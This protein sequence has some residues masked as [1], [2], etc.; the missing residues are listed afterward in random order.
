MDTIY[1][2][3]EGKPNGHFAN[4]ERLLNDKHKAGALF[5]FT[6]GLVFD[7]LAGESA[8]NIV[9]QRQLQGASKLLI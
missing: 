9:Q 4:V 2:A 7:G 5:D 6:A 1:S 8:G 3:A